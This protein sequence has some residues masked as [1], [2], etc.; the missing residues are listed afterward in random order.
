MKKLVSIALILALSASMLSFSA[1][2]TALTTTPT[3]NQ[4]DI[5]HVTVY[6]IDKAEMEC[7]AATNLET[8]ERVMA[9]TPT[10]W[11]GKIENVMLINLDVM[12]MATLTDV[13]VPANTAVFFTSEY[14][15]RV[16]MSVEYMPT[17]LDLYF[18]IGTKSDGTGNH[19]AN[20]ATGGSG[21]AVITPNTSGW[22]YPYLANGNDKVMYVDFSYTSV[23]AISV[24]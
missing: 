15:T 12:P 6:D 22:Y 24:D 21:S 1:S 13:E 2:A 20:K 7:L 3:S 11:E 8:M 4:E 23:A 18:G 14:M 17:N 16:T 5:S 19:W 10:N 9:N